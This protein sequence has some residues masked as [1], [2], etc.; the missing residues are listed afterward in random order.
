MKA[1]K[2]VK[3]TVWIVTGKSE[4]GDD[5]GVYVFG[6]KPTERQLKDICENDAGE[7]DGPG[8]LGSYIHLTISEETVR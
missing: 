4:S 1:E 8:Y 3:K 5:Y 7:W 2:R 6:K